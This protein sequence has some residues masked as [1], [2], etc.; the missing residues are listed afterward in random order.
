MITKCKKALVVAAHPA[1]EV[2][3]CGG[4]MHRLSS[5]GVEVDVLILAD[6]E[7]SRTPEEIEARIYAREERAAEAASVLGANAPRF[8]NFRDH[9]LDTYPLLQVIQAVEGVVEQTK[10]DVV[11]THHKH[12]LNC[13]HRICHQAVTTAC[14]PLP[15]ST[16]QGVYAFEILSST[17][18]AFSKGSEG[19]QP[20]SY[21]DITQ[22]FP[23]K[24][25]AL[26]CYESEM[27]P[28]PHPRSYESV[29]HLARLRGSNVGIQY[30]EAFV[31][32]WD[33]C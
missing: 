25:K 20:S 7:E 17:D 13:D 21:V 27:R 29:E 32:V 4:T 24:T 12:D 26:Q 6:G 30:A 19:F 5:A 15:G 1:D 23:A 14:R 3:G 22:N 16:L 31:A 28:A 9:R 11:L 18:F 2:L 10:P 8:L 33:R